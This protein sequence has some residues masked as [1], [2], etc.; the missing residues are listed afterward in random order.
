METEKKLN[1]PKPPQY[2]AKDSREWWATVVKDYD[3]SPHDFVL[4]RRAC[5]AMDRGEQ[6]RKTIDKEGLTVP[7]QHGVKTHPAVAV[8]RGSA[9]VFIQLVKAL[10]LNKSEEAKRPVGR[11]Q[12]Y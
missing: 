6:A 3:L 9:L 2:L 11:P 4:L 12:Q 10:G 7:T 1:Y 5:E 8:E